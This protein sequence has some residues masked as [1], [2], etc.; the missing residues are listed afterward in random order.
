M[1]HAKLK[2]G[3]TAVREQKTDLRTYQ[4]V[5]DIYRTDAAIHLN[6]EMPGV[7]KTTLSVALD[8]DI[9]ALRGD[10]DTC[11]Y[12]TT[13]RHHQEFGPGR[14]QRSFRLGQQM[15]RDGI[16]A[17]FENGLLQLEIPLRAKTQRRKI[18]IELTE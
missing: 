16:Q 10:T 3:N 15:N 5:V 12:H 6:A 9:L 18:Q 14:Y 4:P 17:S 1:E 8:N 13:G 2:N 11:L 7:D